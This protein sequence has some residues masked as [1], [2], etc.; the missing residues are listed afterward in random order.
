MCLVVASGSGD[1][2]VVDV[3]HPARVLRLDQRFGLPAG[4]EPRL[5]ARLDG[6]EELEAHGVDLGRLGGE[7]GPGMRRGEDARLG[8]LG[9]G[10]ADQCAREE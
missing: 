3:E 4:D 8:G 10:G 7:L 6:Q 9:L 2:G 5:D 1:D